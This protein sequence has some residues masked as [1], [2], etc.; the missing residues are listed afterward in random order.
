MGDFHATSP[1]AVITDCNRCR[2]VSVSVSVSGSVSVPICPLQQVP[3]A[4]QGGAC[5][6]CVLRACMHQVR[7][8][9]CL[10]AH[11][12]TNVLPAHVPSHHWTSVLT[13]NVPS[14]HWRSVLTAHLPSPLDQCADGGARGVPLR[15]ADRHL[16]LLLGSVKAKRIGSG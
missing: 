15:A 6:H 8:R 10:R 7:R 11:H 3:T 13:A 1:F 12:W 2:R 4:V 5:A 9:R 14:H 16:T